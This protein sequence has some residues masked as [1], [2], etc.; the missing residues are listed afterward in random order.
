[1]PRVLI[2]GAA[3]GIGAAVASRLAGEG[4]DLLLADIAFDNLEQLREGLKSSSRHV[5]RR[6]LFR[7]DASVRLP[8]LLAPLRSFFQRTPHS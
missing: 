7:P 6:C 3:S 5:S 2:T 8:T 1:M 4:Y